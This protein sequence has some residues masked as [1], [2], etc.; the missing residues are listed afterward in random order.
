MIGSGGEE[1]GQGIGKGTRDV[2]RYRGGEERRGTQRRQRRLIKI[3]RRLIKAVDEK[4]RTARIS[5][6]SRVISR[7]AGDAAGKIR[8]LA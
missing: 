3:K 2:G 7:G 5:R 4:K 8:L 6:P 1:E